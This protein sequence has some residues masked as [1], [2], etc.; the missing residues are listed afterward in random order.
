MSLSERFERYLPMI[1]SEMRKVV[2]AEESPLTPFYGMMQYHLGWVDERF[3]VSALHS[4]KRVRPVIC[5]LACEAVGGD[6]EDALPA[7]AALELLHNFSLIHDDI[8]DNSST[9]RHRPTVWAVWGVPQ[10]I[11]AGDGMYSLAY[12]ALL[13]LRGRSLP[14]DLVL[15][16]A[17]RFAST[18]VALTEGQYLDMSFE[19]RMDV[20]TAE[21]LRMVEG[22]TAALISTSAYLG[23]LIGGADRA[24][25]ARYSVFGRQ[26]GIAFQM[27]DDILGIWGDEKVTGKPVAS[28][29]LERKKTL[30]VIFGLAKE[31]AE[32]GEG[33][34]WKLFRQEGIAVEEA[35]EAARL[36]E[37]YGARA[38]TNT[39][40]SDAHRLAMTA[41]H[42]TGIENEAQ[43]DLRALAEKLLGRES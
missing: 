25:A 10:A 3:R 27:V 37:E 5:L 19:D 23:S 28:D 26:L 12:R 14:P 1:E 22:K 6:P 41:L 30:P 39:L 4:G 43:E 11:N 16:A 7:A 42:E 2:A 9:R 17:E 29:I 40:A 36:L 31:L 38:Y 35:R 33:P 34:L 24:T 32:G 8:E 21:Y 13:G 20:T 15:D 18:C